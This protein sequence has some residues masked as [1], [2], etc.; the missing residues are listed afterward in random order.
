MK[1]IIALLCSLL[2]VFLTACSAKQ[3]ARQKA[4]EPI[5]IVWWTCDYDYKLNDL[6]K[7]LAKA[8][9]ISAE[10][11]GVTVDIK[12]KSES[13]LE[14]DYNTG[15]Y[16]DAMFSCSWLMNFDQLAR[17]GAFYDITDMVKEKTPALYPGV[18][19]GYLRGV[20]YDSPLLYVSEFHQ[21]GHR[22]DDYICL[23]AGGD[24]GFSADSL[25]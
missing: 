20:Y 24:S 19:R 21:N 11:I 3:P 15:E 17:K 10:K 1:K 18:R 13:Q 14:L 9:E 16:F 4:N 22:I 23:A 8:N 7:V 2:M 6:D 5:N 25:E 12:F